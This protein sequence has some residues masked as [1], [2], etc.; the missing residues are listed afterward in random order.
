MDD[1]CADTLDAFAISFKLETKGH[2]SYVATMDDCPTPG[3][4]RVAIG[5][6]PA[7]QYKEDCALRSAVFAAL[8][9]GRA[10]ATKNGPN[11]CSQQ[12]L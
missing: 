6:K 10:E 1:V 4:V 11:P 5:G 3:V 8:P 7:G 2:P 12:S 9:R